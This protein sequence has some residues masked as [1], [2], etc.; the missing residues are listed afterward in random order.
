MNALLMAVGAISAT[1]CTPGLPSPASPATACAF[2][3]AS[4]DA[5]DFPT[6]V[7][8]VQPE[9][10]D[11]RRVRIRGHL[12]VSNLGGAMLQS[13]K[14]DD[15]FAL[16]PVFTP[17]LFIGPNATAHGSSWTMDAV[18]TACNRRDVVVEG[19][20]RIPPPHPLAPDFEGLVDV[21]RIEAL[22]GEPY[23]LRPGVMKSLMLGEKAGKS[24]R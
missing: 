4:P 9:R 1:A 10:F 18:R 2:G 3:S 11:G 21:T 17:S 12:V 15:D 22:S 8:L 16:S 5:T 6:A 23:L 13:S 7:V 14:W 20:V 19:T 24:T